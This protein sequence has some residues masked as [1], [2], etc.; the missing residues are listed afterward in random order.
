M[1][2]P[3]ASGLGIENFDGGEERWSGWCIGGA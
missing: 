2:T 1:K 3:S